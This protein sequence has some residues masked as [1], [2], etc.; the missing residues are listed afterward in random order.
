M[1]NVIALDAGGAA[2]KAS[3]VHSSRSKTSASA[4]VA[5]FTL[6]N[7]VATLSSSTANALIGQELLDKE[8]HGSAKLRYVRP[9]ERYVEWHCRQQCY[10]VSCTDLLLGAGGDSYRGYC[11]NWNVETDIWSHLFSTKVQ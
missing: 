2:L 8:R 4:A 11:V 6:A 5:P 10:K 9:V 7:Q 1:H 3:V